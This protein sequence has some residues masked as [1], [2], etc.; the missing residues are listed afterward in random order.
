MMLLV[1]PPAGVTPK[2][3]HFFGPRCYTMWGWSAKVS[4]EKLNESLIQVPHCVREA[5]ELKVNH[6]VRGLELL[7]VRATHLRRSE[8]LW[9]FNSTCDVHE[10]CRHAHEHWNWIG[11]E[12]LMNN[13]EDK[14]KDRIISKMTKLFFIHVFLLHFLSTS[15]YSRYWIQTRVRYG[16]ANNSGYHKSYL[17]LCF[18]TVTRVFLPTGKWS[19]V[20]KF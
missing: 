15:P 1:L 7:L 12:C 11:R 19:R 3:S 20:A 18:D 16:I 2:I 4:L 13:M 6:I 10:T 8:H 14:F 17:H 9:I 5:V